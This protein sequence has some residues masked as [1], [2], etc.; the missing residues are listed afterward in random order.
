M[1]G[2]DLIVRTPDGS[3]IGRIVEWEEYRRHDLWN[4]FV[5][6]DLPGPEDGEL[7]TVWIDVGIVTSSR[8]R[9]SLAVFEAHEKTMKGIHG[10]QTS[11]DSHESGADLGSEESPVLRRLE[12]LTSCP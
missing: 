10:Q 11:N 6:A 7:R 8:R 1:T 12:E 5:A 2:P 9:A 3:I 4:G